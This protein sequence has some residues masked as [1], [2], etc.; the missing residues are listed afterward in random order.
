MK[1]FDHLKE[2]FQAVAGKGKAIINYL[3]SDS[4]YQSAVEKAASIEISVKPKDPK[5]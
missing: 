2:V 5:N 4:L 3:L 1:K